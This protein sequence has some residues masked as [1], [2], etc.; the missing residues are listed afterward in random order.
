M[1][2]F[3]TGGTGLIGRAL[4]PALLSDGHAVTVLSRSERPQL[5]A[6]ARS[7]RGDPQE[8][9]PWQ[10]VLAACDACVHLAGESLTSGRWTAERK[11]RIRSSRTEGT[12][13]VAEVIAG[14]GPSVLVSGSA[15][16][17][18]GAQGDAPL[19]EEAPRGEG[20]LAEVCQAWEEAAEAAARRARVV[21]LRTGI[22][23][24]GK[25]G[26]LPL[27][28]LPFKLFVG[29]PVG[30]GDFWQPW[31]HLEDEVGLIRWALAAGDVSGPLNA[32]AP[33]PARNREL[34][35]AVALALHRPN[36]VPVP[37]FALELALGE[38]ASVV[39]T[40]QRA[41][42]AKALRLGYAFGF[43]E[44]DRAVADA[45]AGA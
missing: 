42:P 28:A 4:V 37:P 10:E 5:P 41:V 13:H 30:K 40:G 11:R 31:I 2:V 22:V 24:S 33:A 35:A 38:L 8:R 36:A 1:H 44:L 27:M 34:S 39:T 21:K 23:L 14:R 7:V 6:A 25:G 43:P 20:F 15:V 16:G 29:G 32:T 19:D 45:L 26:A 3:V 12:R 18:Y 17:Y 9:G